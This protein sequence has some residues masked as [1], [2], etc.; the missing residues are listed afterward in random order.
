MSIGQHVE[1]Y[2]SGK[3]AAKEAEADTPEEPREVREHKVYE[4][5]G[6]TP[7][8]PTMAA[9]L[10]QFAEILK[11]LRSSNSDE[12]RGSALKQAELLEQILVKTK[13]ENVAP[14]LQSVY[15][16]PE[17]ERDHPKEPLK[18]KMTWVGYEVKTDTLTPAEVAA[19]NRLTH[20]VYRVT[21][22]DNTPIEFRVTETR[23]TKMELERIDIW[24]PCK[25][26][27]RH[28]HGT[29]LSYCHQAVTG[30]LPTAESL[31]AELTDLKRQIA[32]R[33]A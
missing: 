33:A 31:L 26:E 14:P 30:A 2:L 5:A 3:L 17:G 6:I 9:V 15:S 1:K 22:S 28:N 10:S 16:Y 27:F 21:K 23:N 19:L 8:E 29:M 25:G 11:E 18:C 32:E 4:K 13:P 12:T 24:F 7:P 20:G